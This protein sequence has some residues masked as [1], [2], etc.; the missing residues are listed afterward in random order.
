MNKMETVVKLNVVFSI[1]LYILVLM[2]M[3]YNP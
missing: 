1:L 3:F 2:H